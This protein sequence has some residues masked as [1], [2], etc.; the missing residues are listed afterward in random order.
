MIGHHKCPVHKVAAI[1]LLAGALNL[2]LL[3]LLG[4]NLIE[5]VLGAGMLARIVYILIGLSAVAM[6]MKHHC[7]MCTAGGGT[8]KKGDACCKNDGG[9]APKMDA[10]SEESSSDSQA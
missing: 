10:P 3:G 7:K 9:D 5:M 8:C 2:G 6:L 1:L 4:I